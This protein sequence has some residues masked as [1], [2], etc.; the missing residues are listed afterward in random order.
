M[1]CD[2]VARHVTVGR[3]RVG[4]DRDK[5]QDFARGVGWIHLTTGTTKQVPNSVDG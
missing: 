4:D 5:G 3:L 1:D 2:N